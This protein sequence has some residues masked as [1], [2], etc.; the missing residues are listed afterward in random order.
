MNNN[1]SVY[2]KCM[3]AHILYLTN[4]AVEVSRSIF[5]RTGAVHEHPRPMPDGISHYRIS[6]QSNEWIAFL[7]T[8]IK[9]IKKLPNFKCVYN[10]Y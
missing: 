1:N 10:Y 7:T 4:D 5:S 9:K 8:L 3:Y 6:H 2:I